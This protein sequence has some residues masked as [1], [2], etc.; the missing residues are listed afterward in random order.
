MSCIGIAF[1]P[2]LQNEIVQIRECLTAKGLNTKGINL[3]KNLNLILK[4]FL[5]SVLERV[6]EIEMSLKSKRLC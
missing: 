4:P 3:L 5:I 6:N 1:L 2:I